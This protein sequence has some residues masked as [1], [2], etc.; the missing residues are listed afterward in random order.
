MIKMLSSQQWLQMIGKEKVQAFQEAFTRTFGISL[1][2]LDLEGKT[3]TVWSKS[4]LFCHFMMHNS[5][6][7]CIQERQN[8]LNFS[9]KNRKSRSFTCYMGMTY[10]MCPIF[11]GNEVICIAYGGG[12]VLDENNTVDT[13]INSY[14][15]PSFSEIKLKNMMEL[16]SET[17][18][19]LNNRSDKIREAPQVEVTKEVDLFNNKLSRR[20][21]EIARLICNGMANKEIASKLYISEKTVKTHVSNILTKLEMKDRMQL[22]IYYRV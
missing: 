6:V 15:V 2:L 5:R 9:I 3:L 22:A 12:F 18:N 8:A 13:V 4:S 16:L 19:L 21:G 7:R 11:Y 14:G 17:M 10:F 20:E 1:C